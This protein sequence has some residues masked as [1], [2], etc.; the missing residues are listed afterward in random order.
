LDRWVD[1]GRGHTFLGGRGLA[2]DLR[3]EV[4]ALLRAD[5]TGTVVL[6]LS[7]VEGVSH[8]FADELLSPLSEWLE[9]ELEDRVVLANG[10][11]DVLAE[12]QAVGAMHDLFLPSV[13]GPVGKAAA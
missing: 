6:D 7:G 2:R 4:E 5:P 1:A 12:I 9:E 11:P 13:A 3:E 10:S 8:S